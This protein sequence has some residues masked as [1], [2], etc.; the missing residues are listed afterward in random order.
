MSDLS[1]LYV[2]RERT[3]FFAETLEDFAEEPYNLPVET[4][5]VGDSCAFV[6]FCTYHIW[7]RSASLKIVYPDY[8]KRKFVAGIKS[9]YGLDTS[10][11]H[12]TGLG[13]RLVRY[14]G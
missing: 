13:L 6:V 7:Y 11:T 12:S 5:K 14:S 4:F 9:F 8:H 10:P 1:G 3:P 2:E